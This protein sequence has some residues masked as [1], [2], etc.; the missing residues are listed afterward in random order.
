M[1][2]A[3]RWAVCGGDVGKEVERVDWMVWRRERRGGGRVFGG[4]AMVF[5][6][7][8]FLACSD[9]AVE[10]AYFVELSCL[11]SIW[12]LSELPSFVVVG[13]S[14]RDSDFIE[15]SRFADLFSSSCDDGIK[16]CMGIRGR[17]NS[18]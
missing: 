5:E 6:G 7:G 14:S 9:L 18:L 3:S 16:S 11:S 12:S 8:D 13:G 15:G 4:R 10:G 1:S 2:S 17:G